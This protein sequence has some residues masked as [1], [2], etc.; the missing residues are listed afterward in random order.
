MTTDTTNTSDI[1][2]PSPV[3]MG[4]PCFREWRPTQLRAIS[5][6]ISHTDRFTAQNIATGGGK[7]G[8]CMADGYL[9]GGQTLILT[10][11]KALQAQYLSD[12]AQTLVDIRGR[13]NYACTSRTYA[14]GSPVDCDMGSDMRCPSCIDKSCTYI[15]AKQA[16]FSSQA[17]ITNYAYHVSVGKSEGETLAP[18]L[19]ILDEAHSAHDEVCKLMTCQIKKT[20]LYRVLNEPIPDFKSSPSALSTWLGP[21]QAII[22]DRLETLKANLAAGSRQSHTTY[23]LTRELH[24]KV[25]TSLQA[26]DATWMLQ[27]D[28]QNLTVSPVWAAPYTEQWLFRNAPRVLLLSATL[29]RK[30]LQLL[31]IGNH[32]YIHGRDS[33]RFTVYPW[34][35]PPANQP[36]YFVPLLYVA[37][38]NDL[39]DENKLLGHITTICQDRKDRKG[40]IHSVSYDRAKWLA[41]EL[42]SKGL[43][44]LTHGPGEVEAAIQKH[45]NSPLPT[46]LISP[47][48]TTGYDFPGKACEYQILVKVPS[49][50]R[51]ADPVLDRR[52]K[53]DKE[54]RAYL[55]SQAIA[56]SSGRGRRYAE[57]RCET[58][59]LDRHFDQLYRKNLDLFPPWFQQ[60]VKVR[61]VQVRVTPLPKIAG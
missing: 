54:Y 58:F 52:C 47:V 53:E 1:I 25:V 46:I 59:I 21:R 41:R 14:D 57:D 39:L 22:A 37:Y 61:G 23:R 27:Q 7:S 3:D 26:N 56:Q 17:V 10:T 28:D 48:V 33:Y 40:I 32:N 30:S 60:T 34:D 35:F 44:V 45:K 20:E 8:V 13:A 18:S 16:A 29:N 11:S 12:F 42:E 50:N 51:K 15:R 2:L 36:F 49:P 6:Y 31:G 43:H 4:F 38:S 9:S 55:V 24:R 5:D 19:L